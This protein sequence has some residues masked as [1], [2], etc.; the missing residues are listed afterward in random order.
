MS[1]LAGSGRS[2]FKAA[3][4]AFT[5][6]VEVNAL[7]LT[8]EM[9]TPSSVMRTTEFGLAGS[10]GDNT[11]RTRSPAVE[12]FKTGR[13]PPGLLRKLVKSRDARYV[14]KFLNPFG[15]TGAFALN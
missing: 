15:S 11:K 3:S 10:F 1:S 12:V 14:V 2:E 8:S 13:T 9:G 5:E 7:R 6:V 4:A